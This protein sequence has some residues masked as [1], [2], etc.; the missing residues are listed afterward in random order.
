MRE[1]GNTGLGN[2][3]A[4]STLVIKEVANSAGKSPSD[5]SRHLNFCPH[6]DINCMSIGI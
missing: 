6:F 1:E 5:P 3:S 4:V 2:R